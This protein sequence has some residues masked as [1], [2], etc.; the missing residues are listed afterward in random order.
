MKLSKR[1]VLLVLL[2]LVY[3]G[4]HLFGNEKV[5]LASDIVWVGFV[6]L[7]YRFLGARPKIS[8][9][10]TFFL[11]IFMET[12]NYF[13]Q[14]EVINQESLMLLCVL[15]LATIFIFYVDRYFLGDSDLHLLSRI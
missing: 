11:T 15:I 7:V 4:L 3:I 6:Y 5:F 8:L 12:P 1:L 13:E 9:I 10:F 2:L 14:R